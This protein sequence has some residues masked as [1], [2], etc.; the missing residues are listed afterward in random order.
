MYR[1][2]SAQLVQSF[3]RKRG[4]LAGRQRWW[5][6]RFAVTLLGGKGRLNKLMSTLAL[7]FVSIAKRFASMMSF[8]FDGALNN[9]L[10]ECVFWQSW[11]WSVSAISIKWRWSLEGIFVLITLEVQ[12]GCDFARRCDFYVFTTFPTNKIVNLMN[13]TYPTWNSLDAVSKIFAAQ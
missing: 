3:K 7:H 13:L 10:I 12:R 2:C 6:V 9:L 11:L 5:N 8:A 4:F 1:L